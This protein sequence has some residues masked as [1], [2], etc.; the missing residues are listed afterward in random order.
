VIRQLWETPDPDTG[1]PLFGE[2]YRREEI[3]EGPYVDLAPDIVYIPADM[4]AKALGTLDFSSNKFI[5]S[6]YG[7]SGDHRMEGILAVAGEHIRRGQ[8]IEGA[9]ILDLAPTILYMM[10]CPVPRAMDGR[11]LTSLFDPEA[12]AGRPVR[13]TDRE[14]I[15]GIGGG[16]LGEDEDEAIR[17]QLRG[18]GYVG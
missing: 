1:K 7:N 16:A 9:T 8:E 18:V 3:Y 17:R 6:T 2:V 5:E 11:V 12:I 14:L 10:D 4:S 15:R 13:F